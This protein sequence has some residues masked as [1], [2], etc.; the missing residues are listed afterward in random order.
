MILFWMLVQADIAIL[1]AYL[2]PLSGF[3]RTAHV[4]GILRKVRGIFP[5]ASLDSLERPS[6]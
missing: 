3:R 2:P 1:A 6:K 5:S 4:A